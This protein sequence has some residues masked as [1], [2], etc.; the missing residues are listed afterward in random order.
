M[1]ISVRYPRRRLHVAAWPLRGVQSRGVAHG[2]QNDRIDP[3]SRRPKAR[4]GV[5]RERRE[6]TVAS[7][8]SGPYLGA[9][10][11]PVFVLAATPGLAIAIGGVVTM[12]RPRGSDPKVSLRGGRMM[13]FGFGLFVLGPALALAIEGAIRGTRS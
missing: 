3:I 9:M 8:N 4:L 7:T 2:E 13:V 1:G 5:R 12:L 6:T 10:D 11:W